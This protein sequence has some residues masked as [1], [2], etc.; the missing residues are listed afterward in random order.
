VLVHEFGHLVRRDA[1]SA[2]VNLFLWVLVTYLS[3]A[4]MIETPGVTARVLFV[5]ALVC[6]WFLGRVIACVGSRHIEAD[7]DDFAKQHGYGS[8]LAEYLGNCGT[9]K[10]MEFLR[11]HPTA[12]Q[13]VTALTS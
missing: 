10:T 12:A 11:S 5:V 2:N 8:S 4:C 13:R 7:A 1:K 9:S 3:V 6:A